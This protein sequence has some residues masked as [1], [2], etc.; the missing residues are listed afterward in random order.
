[1][2]HRTVLLLCCA[3]ALLALCCAADAQAQQAYDRQ[4]GHAYNTQ[5]WNRLYHY[6]YVY[7]PQ[8]FW[9]HDYYR[10]S[11]D[12][13]Y[14]YPQEMRVPVYNREWHN[15]YPQPRRYYEGCHFTM[16]TF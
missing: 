15:E 7:Y 8:N 10:S 11:E 14:R 2:S 12:L 9:G 1:M 3:G 13:Y 4:W 16:D 5:D 6:P